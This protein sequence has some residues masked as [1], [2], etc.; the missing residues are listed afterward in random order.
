MSIIGDYEKL[1]SPHYGNGGNNEPN[2]SEKAK[3]IL[4]AMATSH[5]D[6]L[7]INHIRGLLTV[8]VGAKILSPKDDRERAETDAAIKALLGY[9]LIDRVGDSSYKITDKGYKIAD[10]LT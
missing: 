2:L 9:G 8:Q 10:S 7:I 5:G 3:E 6:P 4:K 1:K